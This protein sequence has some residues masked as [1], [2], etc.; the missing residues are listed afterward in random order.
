MAVYL[1]GSVYRDRG[2]V[3]YALD[4]YHEAL[5]LSDT[6]EANADYKMLAKIY[7]Q[8]Y[9]LYDK[10][11]LPELEIE[12]VKKCAEMC[13]KDKDT[14]SYIAMQGILAHP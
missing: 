12:A 13:L 10:V 9:I 1:L 5:E 8:M 7:G 2:D 3:P 11:F 14:L 6:T 4:R